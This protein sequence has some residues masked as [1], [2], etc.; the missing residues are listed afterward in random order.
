MT[1]FEAYRTCKTPEEL[2]EMV[3]RDAK[4]ASL[5]NPD[6]LVVIEQSVNAAAEEKGWEIPAIEQ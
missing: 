3:K 6:R 4:V 1:Y 2:V 5:L